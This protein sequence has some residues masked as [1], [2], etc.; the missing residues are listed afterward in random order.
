MPGECAGPIPGTTPPAFSDPLGSYRLLSE[1]RYSCQGV[2]SGLDD[3][4]LL[5]WTPSARGGVGSTVNQHCWLRL[6]V[7]VRGEGE[8]DLGELDDNYVLVRQN[9]FIFCL[10][11]LQAPGAAWLQGQRYALRS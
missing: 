8:N 4:E 6:E 7:P 11:G 10:L 5:A 3:P 1:G 9:G 2:C